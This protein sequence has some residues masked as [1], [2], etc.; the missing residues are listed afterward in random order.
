[1]LLDSGN[2]KSAG[3]RSL[4]QGQSLEGKCL[5][6]SGNF[7]LASLFEALLVLEESGFVG[8]QL[9]PLFISEKNPAAVLLSSN[10]FLYL[11]GKPPSD[12]SLS[13]I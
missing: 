12:R 6:P 7:L 1:M 4:V 13:R 9:Q 8:P 11:T 2:A 10:L 5:A 3:R